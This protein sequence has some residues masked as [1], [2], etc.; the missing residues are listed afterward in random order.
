[1][2][3]YICLSPNEF[4]HK[5][6]INRHKALNIVNDR[7]KFWCISGC[8]MDNINRNLRIPLEADIQ[9]IY[10]MSTLHSCKKV[11]SFTFFSLNQVMNPRGVGHKWPWQSRT[12]PIVWNLFKS[13]GWHGLPVSQHSFVTGLEEDIVSTFLRSPLHWQTTPTCFKWVRHLFC[14]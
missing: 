1:M 4:Y 11:K 9:Q 12:N 8:I 2:N 3:N 14:L 6:W 5:I 7:A 10:L 13:L